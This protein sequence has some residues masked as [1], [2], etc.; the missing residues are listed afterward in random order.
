MKPINLPSQVRLHVN[1]EPGNTEG[2]VECDVQD[3]ELYKDRGMAIIKSA[4]TIESLMN[5]VL[6]MTFFREVKSDREFVCGH[7]LES[8]KLTFAA[9]R[10]LLQATLERDETLDKQSRKKL[11]KALFTVAQYRNA[12]AHGNISAA[13]DK[14]LLRYF[15][16]TQR[17]E[18]LNETFWTKL[19]VAFNHS[20]DLLSEIMSKH[21]GNSA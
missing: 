21:S 17:E 9:K 6:K 19:E 10:K 11:D 12:F 16:S 1:F 3:Y 15:S 20:S 4:L 2:F 5:Y 7:L 18:E 14:Y 8:D 13:K